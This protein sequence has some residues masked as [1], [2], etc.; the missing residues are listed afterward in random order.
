MEAIKEVFARIIGYVYLLTFIGTFIVFWTIELIKLLTPK[1]RKIKE[2]ER[3][4]YLKLRTLKKDFLV[5]KEEINAH[6][7][8]VKEVIRN[9]SKKNL[10]NIPLG[11]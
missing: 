9:E 11:D 6:Y 2:A 3:A 8:L 4:Y 1:G 5:Q 7:K 10:D